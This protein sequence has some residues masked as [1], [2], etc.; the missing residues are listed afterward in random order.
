MVLALARVTDELHK[1]L[2]QPG[3]VDVIGCD[4]IFASRSACVEAYRTEIRT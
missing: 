1:D 3:L 4:R 2:G